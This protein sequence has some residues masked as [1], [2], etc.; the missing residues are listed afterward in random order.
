[1]CVTVLR[2]ERT[3]RALFSKKYW[4]QSVLRAFYKKALKVEHTIP[5]TSLRSKCTCE[6][7]KSFLTFTFQGSEEEDGLI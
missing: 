4:F 7:V 3:H 1:M 2:E 5:K 6:T